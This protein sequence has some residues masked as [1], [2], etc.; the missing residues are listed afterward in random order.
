MISKQ[1]YGASNIFLILIKA[2]ELSHMQNINGGAEIIAN[3]LP[4]CFR[5]AGGHVL[6]TI[7][8]TRKC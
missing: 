4:L 3:V 7:K 6:R 8:D 5:F 1:G 2:I